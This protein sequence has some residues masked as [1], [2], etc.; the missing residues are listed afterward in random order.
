MLNILKQI[1]RKN[2]KFYNALYKCKVALSKLGNG[3]KGRNNIIN[4][5]SLISQISYD[6][7]GNNNEIIIG[8][9]SNIFNLKIFIRG[10]NHKVKIGE[11]CLIKSGVIWIE[12]HDCSLLIDSFTT[13]ED[14][15]FGITEPNSKVEV[16]KD[17][18]LS[19]GIRILTGDSHSIIDLNSETRINY[20]SNVKIGSHVWIGLDSLILKGV[21]IGKDSIVGS[22]SILT[23]K[24]GSNV[25]IAGSPA[26]IIKENITWDRERTYI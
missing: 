5:T 10:D 19:S 11:N 2:R 21:E 14:A 25:I 3:I 16:G 24:Y 13:I 8:K 18:M 12:D 23:K 6:I 1:L 26:K 22:K 7:I 15:H 17:C 20:A 9:D 4:D